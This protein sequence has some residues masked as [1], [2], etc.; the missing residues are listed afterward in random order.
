MPVVIYSSFIHSKLEITKMFS[1]KLKL[2][3]QHGTY[4]GILFHSKRK[5]CYQAMRSC[6][7]KIKA[8]VQEK[9]VNVKDNLVSLYDIQ[10]KRKLQM[11]KD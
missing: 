4:N 11:V 10:K 1:S 3:I 8:Y 6:G 5:L 7:R 9:E 2:Y